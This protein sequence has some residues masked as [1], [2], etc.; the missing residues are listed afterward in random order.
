MNRFFASGGQ[1]I[2]ASASV[3][4]VNIQLLY[5][6]DTLLNAF[7]F[8][9]TCLIVNSSKHLVGSSD[10]YDTKGPHCLLRARS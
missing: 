6:I 8:K 9:A 4:P 3:L 2:G 1:S 7:W 5:S 10:S